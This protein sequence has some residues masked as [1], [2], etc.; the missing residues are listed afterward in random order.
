MNRVNPV[1]GEHM[2]IVFISNMSLHPLN[3]TVV[4][5]LRME[6]NWP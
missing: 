1:K 6:I 5:N 3:S 4:G 2:D